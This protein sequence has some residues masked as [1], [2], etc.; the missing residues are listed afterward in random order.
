MAFLDTTKD[1]MQRLK[2]KQQMSNYFA[3]KSKLGNASTAVGGAL[4]GLGAANDFANGDYVN[5]GLNTAKT[6]ATFV[7][8]G[9]PIAAAL[10]VGQTL[11]NMFVPNRSQEMMQK[12][13][14]AAN[15][16]QAFAENEVD[17][18]RQGLEQ[19]RQQNLQDMQQ[20]QTQDNDALVKD[21]LG[22]VTGGASPVSM[23]T[24]YAEES[25]PILSSEDI[26]AQ[27]WYEQ[28]RQNPQFMQPEENKSLL[29]D[30]IK[31]GLSDFSAGYQDN[32]NTD[33]AHG[34]LMQGITTGGAAPV[35]QGNTFN[36][37]A[38]ENKKSIMARLGELA[39]TGQR[40][41]AHPL[42]QA[43]IAGMVSRAAGGGI[44]DIAKA[45]F[46]YGSQKAAADRYYQ[47]VTGNT[48]RPFLNSYAAQ[49]VTN[50]R[51]EDQMAQRQQQWMYEQMLRKE[52]QDWERNYK[53]KKDERDYNYK[54]NKDSQDRAIKR[55]EVAARKKYWETRGR[56]DRGNNVAQQKYD[57]QQGLNKSIGQF[58]KY[59]DTLA[60]AKE[61]DGWFAN[62]NDRAAIE[63]A[64]EQYDKA[65][66]FMINTYGGDFIKYAKE[67]GW[68]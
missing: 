50:K 49:D 59:A 63:Q 3:D 47:Q 41:M 45:A 44:D 4:S 32:A 34:D 21:I 15:E 61:K 20:P 23:P 40:V 7:P 36:L 57:Y 26:E 53:T 27:K 18:T 8:G 67:Q 22:R 56:N 66:E 24:N 37:G 31:N 10:Q 52:Q 19:Q 55:E 38:E 5:G 6:V 12:S 11:K 43:A 51:L 65:R 2:N 30:K 9:Q 35:Q 42:T 60:K 29:I 1:L 13:M 39:G 14:Q 16:S 58:Q 25:N 64:Q 46:Q 33:F 17:Q 48:N 54:V 62:S 68:E 28:Q